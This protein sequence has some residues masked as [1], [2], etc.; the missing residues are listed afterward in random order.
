M[1]YKSYSAGYCTFPGGQHI[2][3]VG[4]WSVY[5][6]FYIYITKIKKKNRV[7]SGDILR[8]N[9]PNAPNRVSPSVLQTWLPA[10]L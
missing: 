7:L 3:S 1:M 2:D 8:W 5:V 4:S 6:N 10:R 9:M